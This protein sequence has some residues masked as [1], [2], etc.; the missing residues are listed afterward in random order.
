MTES[1]HRQAHARQR[2]VHEVLLSERRRRTV[3]LGGRCS[4]G[5]RFMNALCT[6]ESDDDERVGVDVDDVR[7]GWCGSSSGGVGVE[8]K[9]AKSPR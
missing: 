1:D 6:A 5:S 3:M 9:L 7:C 2:L 8:S 4:D